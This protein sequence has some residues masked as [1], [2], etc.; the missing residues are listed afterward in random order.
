METFEVEF[1]TYTAEYSANSFY[2]HYKDN[3]PQMVMVTQGYLGEDGFETF[4]RGQVI[5]E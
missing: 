3:L 1:E 4:D 5:R 2:E